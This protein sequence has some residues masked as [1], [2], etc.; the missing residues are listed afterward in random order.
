VA[1]LPGAGALHGQERA[2]LV[3]DETPVP[4]TGSLLLG[5]SAAETTS[6]AEKAG[7]AEKAIPAGNADVTSVA[8]GAL[9]GR[10]T[11]RVELAGEPPLVDGR[12]DD[13][14]WRGA[15]KLTS[16]VQERPIE[17]EL[18]TED[19]EIYIAYDS[20]NIYFGIYAHYSDPG[21]IRANRVDR[22]RTGRD[23][24][25]TVFFDP[26]L[27]QQR[28][29]AFSVNGYGVQG[30]SLMG[31]RGGGGFGGF[32]GGRGGPGGPGDSSWDAL[33][34]SAGRLVEDG[35]TAEMAIP[36]KSLRYPKQA[37]AGTHRWGFQI[38]RQI[39]G[40]DETVVW[41]PT[42]RDVIGFLSQM[43]VLEGMSDLSTSRNLELLPTVTAIQS[44]SL[45]STGDYGRSGVQEGGVSVKYG[46]T[47]NLT[48]DF[49]ANPDF[50]QIESDRPQIDVNQRFPLFFS[51]QRPF[52]LE[53]QEVFRLSGR[54]NLVHTRTMIDPQLGAK[55]TGKVGKMTMGF[56]AAN[57]E[58]PG[59]L[60]D[61]SDPAFGQAATFAIARIRYDF[62][63]ESSI[64]LIVTDREFVD[65]YSRVGGIDGQFRIGNNQRAG[66]R[67]V[68]SRHRDSAGVELSGDV[69][70]GGYRKEG[71]NLSYSANYFS[72]S[73][74]FRTDTGF[75]RRVDQRRASG[76]ASYRWWPE[77]WIRSFGPRLS[78]ERNY[79]FA[80]TLQDRQVGAGGNFSFAR[81]ISFNVN[82]NRDMER[83][84]GVKFE[85]TRY[86][87]GGIVSTNRVFSFGGFFNRGD[88]IRYVED[89][90]LGHSSGLN[91][92]TTL[93]PFS[94]L[95]SDFNVTTTRFTDVRTDTPVFD[96]KIF[97]SLVTY[98][99]TER[100]LV[101]SILEHNTFDRTLGANLLVTYRVNSGTVF[102]VGYDD[103]YRESQNI[104]PLLYQTP[105]LRRTNRAFF[106]KLQIL[107]R[108]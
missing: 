21:L 48:L 87:F 7:P 35:W 91:L 73:P 90:Y 11:V 33:F 100:L 56:L 8:I 42:S 15:A 92:F 105:E 34:S 14:A 61:P 107:F 28:G 24:T 13:V 36:F 59:K 1:A 96:V 19:T 99:L 10:P 77:S 95:Q 106:T 57:D 64:G 43:G 97:R 41:A 62:R 46:I 51:E 104:D 63:P 83:F 31:S 26:F 53:G 47:S 65:Q 102:F 49:A 52:F 76:N 103:R 37:G 45:G 9:A 50:S 75:I 70:D 93:R 101:R 27:D 79:T 67:I 80:G 60:D 3:L 6:R 54:L 2:E 88:S 30:D 82:Y 44:Q 72:I 40:K 108:Y 5:G 20:R 16:F 17:G 68:T 98:Q 32:G 84:L 39:G 38:Q 25:V 29:Y 74:G 89:P 23:D 69:V 12:L 78:Y 94:R 66:F 22:D 86:G 58:A 71:R 55:L 85:K 81:N 4:A 18:A